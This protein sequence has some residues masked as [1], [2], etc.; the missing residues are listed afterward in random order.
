MGFL[1]VVV[2]IVVVVDLFLFL[3]LLR[4]CFRT[5][6]AL[7]LVRPYT[8]KS[9]KIVTAEHVYN[10]LIIARGGCS[11]TQPKNLRRKKCN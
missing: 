8:V 5:D 6:R 4:L 1:S 2:V 10:A 9:Y 3:C 7:L 11:C